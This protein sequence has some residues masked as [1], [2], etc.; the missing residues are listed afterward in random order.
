MAGRMKTASETIEQILTG[1]LT[2]RDH[3]ADIL[4]EIRK[5]EE[6]VRAYITLEEESKLEVFAKSVEKALQA[7]LRPRLAGLLVA[8]KDNISTSFMPTTA[9]S[10]VLR[11]YVPP[12][13]ATVVERILREGGIVIGKANMDEFAMGSTTELS[14]YGPTR[15]PWDLERV[16]GG[17]SGGSAAALA[18]GGAD[19]ALGSDTGGSIRLP[20]AYTATYGLKP[21]YGLVSRYGLI[22]YAN[23]LEQI[24][25]MARSVEDIA[26]LLDVIAG[27]DPRDATSLR[28]ERSSYYPIKP[29]YDKRPRVCVP[30]ELIEGSEEHVA[31]TIMRTLDRL[32]ANGVGVEYDVSIPSLTRALPVYYTIALAEAASNLARYDGKL[33]PFMAKGPTY[34]E[35]ASG[36]RR[37]GFGWEVRRRILLGVMA[38]SEG[39]RDE[40]YV[41]AAKGRRLIRDDVLKLTSRCFIAGAVSP[42][43]PPRLGERIT[44]PLLL[45][46][47]DVYTVVANLAGV[48]SLTIPVGFHEGL[49]VGMQVMGNPLSEPQLLSLGLLLE[50]LTGLRGVKAP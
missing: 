7:G 47:L 42:V 15:N 22:P 49:P 28:I 4:D 9:G 48:P 23:S 35:T 38:L 26:L 12:F 30:R 3:L 16:P 20:A 5:R 44:D 36:T 19:L 34:T 8:V 11:G 2:P 10:K 32:E 43:L 18:Y 37:E 6:I 50:E 13:N 24:G 21:T 40:F 39:Y 45:Y 25:P 1:S 14:A 27:Y 33:Y 41:A 29:S 46:A 17:S 31:K